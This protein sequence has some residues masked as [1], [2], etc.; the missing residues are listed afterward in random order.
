MV[1]GAYQQDM[2]DYENVVAQTPT[3]TVT[4]CTRFA[5]C[6][7][8]GLATSI[9]SARNVHSPFTSHAIFGE[10]E[11]KVTDKLTLTAGARRF[12]SE[13]HTLN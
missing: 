2:N 10:A 1:G 8:T 12:N 5:D 11:Y 6:V 4:A 13:Q 9:V 7:A 3:N